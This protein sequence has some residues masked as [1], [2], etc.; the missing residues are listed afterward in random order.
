MCDP[1]AVIP[2]PPQAKICCG[3]QHVVAVGMFVALIVSFFF[4]ISHIGSFGAQFGTLQEMAAHIAQDEAAVEGFASPM[5][6]AQ[7]AHVSFHL[8]AGLGI[9]ISV[10]EVFNTS[11]LAWYRWTVRLSAAVLVQA[12]A[13]MLFIMLPVM[14]LVITMIGQFTR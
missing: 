13:G 3:L 4:Y 6:H 2:T 8:F 7:L 5:H 12:F 9:L 14:F 11:P 1:H 10:S